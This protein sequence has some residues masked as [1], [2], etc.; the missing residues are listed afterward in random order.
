M[1]DKVVHVSVCKWSINVD[2]AKAGGQAHKWRM[3]KSVNRG[4]APSNDMLNEVVVQLKEKHGSRYPQAFGVA[5]DLWANWILNQ[6]AGDHDALINSPPP[7]QL[8]DNDNFPVAHVGG[9]RILQEQRAQNQVAL[10]QNQRQLDFLHNVLT[11]STNLANR[12]NTLKRQAEELEHE[13]MYLV[14]TVKRGILVQE[15]SRA[16]LQDGAQSL[17]AQQNNLSHQFLTVNDIPDDDH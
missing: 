10:G 2:N 9:H 4:G 17:V 13:S 6:P 8:C 5:W 14:S 11:Q 16:L 1:P 7:P 15:E 12:A 3:P